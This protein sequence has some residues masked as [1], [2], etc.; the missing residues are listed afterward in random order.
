LPFLADINA[1]QAH[2]PN[3]GRNAGAPDIRTFLLSQIHKNKARALGVHKYEGSDDEA[4]IRRP[5][6]LVW[7]RQR[8]GKTGRYY[9]DMRRRNKSR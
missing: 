2:L 1:R 6:L 9:P 5:C 8:V 7:G 3:E 4:S